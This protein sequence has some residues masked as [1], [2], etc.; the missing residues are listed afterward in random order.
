M[1]IDPPPQKP[2]KA[3]TKQGQTLALVRWSARMVAYRK[4][5][6]QKRAELTADI[7]EI[8]RVWDSL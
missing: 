3:M 6:T 8:D 7:A 1:R 5:L 4:Y 2:L